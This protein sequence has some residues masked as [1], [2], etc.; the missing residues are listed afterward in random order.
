MIRRAFRQ[1]HAIATVLI[2]WIVASAP[3]VHATFDLT[4]TWRQ[5]LG[6]FDV[7]EIRFTQSGTS[8]IFHGE[9]ND[10]VGVIDPE[11]G[12]FEIVLIE[13][14]GCPPPPVT[15]S[16]HMLDA[17]HAA[18]N[19]GG[20]RRT[21]LGSGRCEPWLVGDFTMVR[22]GVPSGTPTPT[23]TATHSPT[24]NFGTI[25]LTG[26]FVA[27]II[28]GV[29]TI[30]FHIIQNGSQLLIDGVEQEIDL[31]TGRWERVALRFQ[32][33]PEP[34]LTIYAQVLD[35]DH[36]RFETLGHIRVLGSGPCRLFFGPRYIAVRRGAP[37]YTAAPSQTP[38]PTRTPMPTKT[39]TRFCAGDCNRDR[40]VTVSE[41]QAL[42]ACA[43]MTRPLRARCPSA[44]GDANRNG[45][46]E[47]AEINAAV[48]NLRRGCP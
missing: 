22:V 28:P 39:P 25:D 44:C 1:H 34:P 42:I 46:I 2:A 9:L 29:E 16:G 14:A 43:R 31:E 36:I 27:D 24:P 40:Q 17:D 10:R 35:A 47:I 11:T 38:K 19:I 48:G 13:F 6:G 21:Q 23:P 30:E 26:T 7:G 8:F 4:G 18:G 20:Y 15:M 5:T 37:T 32:G 12:A 41:V 33:C 45:V 3:A